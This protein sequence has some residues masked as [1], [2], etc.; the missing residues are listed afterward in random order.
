MDRLRGDRLFYFQEEVPMEQLQPFGAMRRFSILLISLMMA[1]TGRSD[2]AYHYFVNLKEVKGDQ[3]KVKLVPPDISANEIDFMFPAVVPG[4]YE[5]YDFGRFI[6][7]F[8]AEGKNG[9]K[10]N[11]TK[12]NANTYRLNPASE[13]SAITYVV[14]D[15]FDKCDLPAAKEK[16]IFE[17]GG[18]SFEESKNFSLNMH[19]LFGYFRGMTGSR[20]SLEFQ[21][22]EGFYPSTGI[23]SVSTGTAVDVL[24][25]SDYHKLVDS[26]VMYCRPDTVS[27]VIGGAKVTVSCYSPRKMVTAAF[28]SATL[29]DLLKAQQRYLGGQLP[30]NRY[31]FLFHFLERPSQS[32]SAGALEHSYS[33]FYVM[34]EFD[35]VYL[36]QQIRD[37][38]AHEFFH[39]V[40]PL[41]IHSREIGAFDYNQPEMSEHLW[42]YEGMTEYAAHH[43][44][45]KGGLITFPEFLNI[46]L[47]KYEESVTSYNDT[48]SFTYMSKHV[49]DTGIH[50]QYGNV[51]QKGAVTGMCLD[52]LL[53]DLSNGSYG[54]Q[55]LMTGLSKIYGKDRSFEDAALFNEI[56]KLTWPEVGGFLRTHVGGKVP[57]PIE[58]ILG[59]VGID[60]TR[61]ETTYNVSLGNPDL[62]FNPKTGR[63]FVEGV[64]GLDAFGKELGYKK[65]DELYSLNGT[66]LKPESMKS[67]MEKYYT[68]AKE[69]DNLVIELYRKGLLKWKKR[70]LEAKVFKVKTV[71]TNVVRIKPSPTAK[72]KQTFRA[73]TGL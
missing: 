58:D 53:R 39:I 68:T 12:V 73:W 43:A 32:G 55:D 40:T 26:P 18:S 47:E 48:M 15:T 31:V 66:V 45:L 35:S 69:G 29:S 61:E 52:I 1:L 17:P 70:K 67:V 20:F 24:V 19:S 63:I 11:V 3:L 41:N 9:V 72:Q 65:G 46:M 71:N 2:G 54:T 37:I 56:E 10:I 62:N 14:D 6:S 22:P 13:V 59:R 5:R 4:T 27:T 51:Y 34:P 42:M 23:E 25:A 7:D 49:L 33:S 21:K 8:K 36:S 16:V 30:V 57:L 50:H 28:I 38:A 64:A 44:Q 60:F